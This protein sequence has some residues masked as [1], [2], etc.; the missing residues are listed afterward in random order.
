[1]KGVKHSKYTTSK[2]T[3]I[4]YGHFQDIEVPILTSKAIETGH[5]HIYFQL[6]NNDF[7]SLPLRYP[8]A[9][10]TATIDAQYKLRTVRLIWSNTEK[11][12]NTPPLKAVIA[13]VIVPKEVQEEYSSINYRRY[14]EVRKVFR[15]RR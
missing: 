5:V 2:W 12:H 3:R 11:V 4:P 7:I 6:I 14:Q 13:V 8:D 15:L 1:M 10:F 9:K